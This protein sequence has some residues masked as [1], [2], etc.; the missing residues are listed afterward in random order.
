LIGGSIDATY[1]AFVSGATAS[2]DASTDVLTFTTGGNT[3]TYQMAGDYTG[4]AF[5]LSADGNGDT[6]IT[7]TPCYCAGT[8]IR[9]DHGEVAVE[10]LAVGDHVLTA[11]GTARPVKWIGC[12]TLDF[13]RHPAPELAQP[14]LIR[15]DA[16]ADGVPHRDLYV[17]PDHGLLLNDML[18]PARL[19]VNGASIQT[20][21]ACKTVTYYHVELDAHDILLAENLPAESYLDTGNRGMFENSDAA[22]ILHPDLTNDQ[23]RRVAQSCRPFADAPAVVEP[24]WHRLAQRSVDLG[25]ALPAAIQTTDDPAL[26]VVIGGRTIRPLSRQG[27]RYIFVLPPTEAP[28]QLVSLATRPSSLR[29]WAEDRRRLGV[30][31]SRL[32]LRQGA[33]VD[34]IP[35]DHP[36]LSRG[37]WDVEGDHPTLWRW[38]DGAATISSA[39]GAPTLLEVTVAHTLDYPLV[40]ATA[41]DDAGLTQAA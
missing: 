2:L 39:P 24:I 12:R 19:L 8:R 13:S 17:S 25:L 21:S 4:E 35:L 37:W 11:D 23:A 34:V 9:T 41:A 28:I 20:V 40:E 22:L 32:T 30:M 14:I 1:A 5:Q 18:V 29:P 3:Y 10:R 16:I 26:H 36:S 27:D 33:D 38:T 6:L 7:L 15:A 31:I